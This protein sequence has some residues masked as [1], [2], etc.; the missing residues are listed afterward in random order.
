M[1][2]N[3]KFTI[4]FL[5][6]AMFFFASKTFAQPGSVFTHVGTAGISAGT[7]DNTAFAVSKSDNKMYV[8]YR[9]NAN[10]G[11]LTV[12]QY[13]GTAWSV[14][15]SAGISAGA[16]NYSIGIAT[17]TTLNGNEVFVAYSDAANGNRLT[18]MRWGGLGWAPEGGAGSQS[19][20]EASSIN[21]TVANNGDMFVAYSDLGSGTKAFVKKRVSG[22]WTNI[23]G[24]GIS[25][26]I[27]DDIDIACDNITNQPYIVY[28]DA[29]AS[30]KATVRKYNG[31]T[32]STVGI[33]GFTSNTVSDCSIAVD[34]LNRPN[35]SYND[36]SVNN[37]A[38]VRY[39]DG[40]TWQVLGFTGISSNVATYTSLV[41]DYDNNAYIIYKD[42]A[43]SGKATVRKYNGTN[44]TT[45]TTSGFSSSNADFTNIEFDNDQN[46]YVAYRDAG[47]NNKAVVQQLS[48]TS[49]STPS[50]NSIPAG[51]SICAGEG[52]QLTSNVPQNNT[53]YSWYQQ[54]S[55]FEDV[56]DLTQLNDNSN[57]S[58]AAFSS[59]ADDNGNI[60]VVK[61]QTDDSM[62]VVKRFAG[63]V[64]QTIGGVVGKS[65]GFT[66]RDA[67]DI[68]FDADGNLYVAYI[69]FAGA[70]PIVVK[71]FVN[72]NWVNFGPAITDRCLSASLHIN[73]YGIMALATGKTNGLAFYPIVFIN[74][75]TGWIETPEVSTTERMGFL[76]VNI[77]RL[78]NVVVAYISP[79][80]NLPL[81]D[82]GIPKAYKY[83]GTNWSNLP[84]GITQTSSTINIGIDKNNTYYINTVSA[85]PAKL[86]VLRSFN[87]GT[88]WTNIGPTDLPVFGGGNTLAIDNFGT[89]YIGFLTQ[90]GGLDKFKL[91]KYVST[92]WV[93]L[94]ATLPSGST[95]SQLDIFF[96][97]TKNV[98]LLLEFQVT[99]TIKRGNIFRIEKKFLSTGTSRYLTIPG[100]FFV[101][102]DAGCNTP[103]TS[104]VA[105]ITQ[106]SPTNNW[107]GAVSTEFNSAGNWSC[108][109]I[110]IAN[111]D[112]LIPAGAA[113]YPTLSS[114]LS[115]NVSIKSLTIEANASLILNGQTLNLTGDLTVNAGATLN[116]SS[117]NSK[118]AMNGAEAQTISGFNLN[119]YDLTINNPKNVT[120]ALSMQ[121]N[122]VFINGKLI[123]SGVIFVAN[124]ITGFN[125][126]RYI[127]TSNTACVN[128]AVRTNI[129]VGESKLIPIGTNDS[130][131]TPITI[132]HTSPTSP[133]LITVRVV[134][135]VTPING[136]NINT[137]VN[138]YW[139]FYGSLNINYNATVQWNT[140]NENSLFNRSLSGIYTINSNSSTISEATVASNAAIVSSTSFS[141]TITNFSPPPAASAQIVK[142]IFLTS[143]ATL[144]PIQL[145]NFSVKL[146][147]SNY[148]EANWQITASSNPKSFIIERSNDGNAFNA[149]GTV[150]GNLS[151][152]YSF[153]DNSI[154]KNGYQYYRLKMT[155][156][157]GKTTYSNIA[158]VFVNNGSLY[159][160]NIYPQP[161]KGENVTVVI[162]S[163]EKNKLQLVVTDVVGRT[164]STKIVVVEKGDNTIQIPVSQLSKGAY[165]LTGLIDNSKT[166]TVSLIKD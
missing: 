25:A 141:R 96:D 104:S 86:N 16:V 54:L 103:I 38:T 41:F 6:I 29:T 108:G 31:T 1:K 55:A 76:D 102:A 135:G 33:T 21:M 40:S 91:V 97:K 162:S 81:Y 62:I 161:T 14:L 107:T 157:D 73:S 47:V 18:V 15:G 39:Y 52:I 59:V 61:M 119:I 137:Y 69:D 154:T 165:F 80:L 95:S 82:A 57:N 115:S 136:A 143:T 42:N 99:T 144:L 20:D 155:D 51:F 145:L 114:A 4:R 90:V 65:A 67:T 35:V 34:K 5:A 36:G 110:P 122:L 106:T 89:P 118:I 72:N 13:T 74:D 78:G 49:P 12:M 11:K 77:D 75:G 84:L 159:I 121:G 112:V 158:R 87:Q 133:A 71:K 48:C 83:D 132:N 88:T 147:S 70:K 66:N 163:T 139:S 3:Y 123:A 124:N 2:K 9:D 160:S 150:N 94:F 149:I 151:T 111:D 148:V 79:S 50:I 44:W 117:I 127:V 30:G 85:S 116:A 93:D 63:G 126:N 98:P 58:G 22:A 53:V 166:N 134:D 8:A 130:S 105:T 146:T 43:A 56:G 10:S 45:V 164:M 128:C 101:I 109:R 27:A 32:W 7:V 46:I 100:N 64:W 140:N 152:N 23:G 26:G 156:L 17:I 37:R 60:F 120:G 125:S 129:L 153:I 68:A 19:T 92:A 131:Y 28:K 142:N 138:K 24:S 113:R